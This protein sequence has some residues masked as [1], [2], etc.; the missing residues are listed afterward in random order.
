MKEECIWPH[1]FSSFS[2]AKRII[3]E[4]I[5]EYNTDRLHQELGYL[6]LLSIT[7]KN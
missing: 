3:E 4:W 1:S 6:S 5:R 2:E 7:E